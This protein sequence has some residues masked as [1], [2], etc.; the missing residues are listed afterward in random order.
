MKDSIQNLQRIEEV[1]QS[2]ALDT[3]Y[4]YSLT[5]T[6]DKRI[7]SGGES[8]TISISSYDLNEKK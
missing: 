1:I 8:G 7:V 5:E 6:E 4:I 2:I 3:S